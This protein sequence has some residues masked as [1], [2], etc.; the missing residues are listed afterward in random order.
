MTKKGKGKKN[1]QT[2]KKIQQICS[3]H[4]RFFSLFHYVVLFV[5]IRAPN[6]WASTENTFSFG[7]Q[8]F[9]LLFT[10]THIEPKCSSN[11]VKQFCFCFCKSNI[12]FIEIKGERESEW[13]GEKKKWIQNYRVSNLIYFVENAKWFKIAACAIGTM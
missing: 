5:F 7:S 10:R 8:L 2:E 12:N 13:T 11:E 4:F 9:R 6:L 1:T 3:F